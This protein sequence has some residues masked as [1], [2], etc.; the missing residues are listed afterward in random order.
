MENERKKLDKYEKLLLGR[1]RRA[2][3]GPR[4]ETPILVD[5]EGFEILSNLQEKGMAVVKDCLDDKA[6]GATYPVCLT[7]KGWASA[8]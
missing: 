4:H 6:E 5:R 2:A 3:K 7:P 8:I 1:I